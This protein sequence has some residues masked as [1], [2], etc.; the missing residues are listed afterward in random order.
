LDNTHGDDLEPERRADL[1]EVATQ[2][3]RAP[4]ENDGGCREDAEAERELTGLGFR[5][6]VFTPEIWMNIRRRYLEQIA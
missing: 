4:G 2:N 6:L 3:G 5:Q 1:K